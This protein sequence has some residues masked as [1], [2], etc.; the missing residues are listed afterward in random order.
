M[1]R[2]H[3]P[4][5]IQ[6]KQHQQ[7][8]GRARHRP[9]AHTNS[10]SSQTSSNLSPGSF[11]NTAGRRK[12][13]HRLDDP[14]ITAMIMRCRSLES[15]DAVCQQHGHRF[16]HLHV[17]CAF[18]RL[19]KTPDALVEAH[20]SVTHSLLTSLEQQFVDYLPWYTAREVGALHRFTGPA[21]HCRNSCPAE[22][23]VVACVVGTGC[24]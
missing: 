10:D 11:Y 15:L 8:G 17:A 16:N 2:Q 12:G 19:A 13:Q 24:V 22:S 9:A 1:G 20:A 4:H 18:N 3:E 5:A 23:V 6:R 7:A 21:C 14:Q